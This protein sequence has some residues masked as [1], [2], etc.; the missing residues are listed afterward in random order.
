M[1]LW[2][3]RRK[4]AKPYAALTDEERISRYL[5]LLGSLPPSIIERAHASA[6]KDLPE[7]ERRATFEQLLPFMTEQERAERAEPALLAR[8]LRRAQ[9]K[10]ADGALAGTA[11]GVTSTKV[12]DDATAD[13][14]KPDAS[15]SFLFR[16]PVL[17]GLIAYQF[18]STQTLVTYFTLG[19]GSIGL[20]SEPGWVSDMTGAASAGGEGFGGDV[21]G[22][23]DGG[24][25][26]G[27]D[28]GGGFGGGF[29]GG[30]FGG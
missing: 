23:F 26:F 7:K 30:G 9:A 29:D 28:F 27:G 10:G 11:P 16:D 19:A 17:L 3:R 6:F 24:G 2:N 15:A 1:A 20:E 5:Y 18:L 22:G 21:G 13:A 12:L 8:V 25:G 14:A 4:A